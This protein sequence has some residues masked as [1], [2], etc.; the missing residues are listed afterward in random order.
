VWPAIFGQRR[1][2]SGTSPQASSAES[3]S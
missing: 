1:P 2:A 3:T